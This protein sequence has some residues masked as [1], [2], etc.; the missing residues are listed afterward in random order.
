MPTLVP[1]DLLENR[2]DASRRE[3][4][5]NTTICLPISGPKTF[6]RCK[7]CTDTALCFFMLVPYRAGNERVLSGRDLRIAIFWFADKAIVDGFL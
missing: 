1:A 3:S 7:V 2:T 5:G 4:V 6:L